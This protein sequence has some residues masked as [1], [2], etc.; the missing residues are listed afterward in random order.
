MEYFGI[1]LI[2]IDNNP[3]VI[4]LTK[5]S[6]LSDLAVIDYGSRPATVHIIVWS[7]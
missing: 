5:M 7:L 6:V 4:V 1:F 3:R 2:R